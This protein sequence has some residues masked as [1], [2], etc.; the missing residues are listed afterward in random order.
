[1]GCRRV[2]YFDNGVW[3]S[4]GVAADGAYAAVEGDVAL[5]GGDQRERDGCYARLRSRS[6]GCVLCVFFPGHRLFVSSLTQ[7]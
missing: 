7:P 5:W 3:L 2:G 1:M 4:V 6:A